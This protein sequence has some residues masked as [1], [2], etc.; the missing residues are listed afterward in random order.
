[1]VAISWPNSTAPGLK[2]SEGAGRLKNCYAEPMG[3]GARDSFVLHRVPGLSAFGTSART[4]YRG[5]IVVA[6][7]LYAGFNGKLE[8]W[9]SS[10]GASSNVG[11]LTGTKKGFFASNNA[12]TPDKVFVDPDG[13]IAT[14]TTTTV[15]NSFDADLPACN[16]VTQLDGYFIFTTGSGQIWATAQNSTSVDALSFTT[17]QTSGG[18]L[19]GITWQGRVIAFGNKASS[20]WNDAATS[21][22]PLA[23]VTTIQRGIA[24]PYCVAGF[25][26]NF[27]RG[28]HF[29]GDDNKVYRLD[30]LSPVPVSPPD[31]DGLIESVTDKTTIE[32]SAYISRGHG[33]IEV[34][35]PAWTW[36][37]NTSTGWWH[38]KTLY[39]GLRSRVAGTV[40][41]FS[42]WLTGD[43]SSGNMVEITKSSYLD[44]DQPIIAEVWSKPIQKFPEQIRVASI[45]I[46]M[47]VG[48]GIASG[49]DPI[50]TDPDIEVDWSDDGGQTF[51]TPRIRKVGRQSLGK[52]RVRINQCGRSKSQGRVVRVKMSSPVHF[53]LMGGE[54]AAELKAA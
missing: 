5:G 6:G 28:V 53:G 44:V 34:T 42:K 35:C 29:V 22:F 52:T 10:G 12:A 38:E 4:G 15:T 13:N 1:M 21:P 37:L 17:D 32:M 43:Y 45:W 23:K 7:V 16:S 39:L 36:V 2:S 25:E 31:L 40:Y 24:G 27:S 51:S 14:F 33:F 9:T 18:L 48:V 46:D 20:V 30:G 50:A 11:N 47:A 8:K 19:R 26:D 54:M 41:A 3:G 49:T